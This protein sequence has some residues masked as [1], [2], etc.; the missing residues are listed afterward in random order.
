MD[1]RK[2]ALDKDR[3]EEGV[4]FETGIGDISVKVKRIGDSRYKEMLQKLSRPYRRQIERNTFD[5]DKAAELLSRALAEC[6]LVDWK[7]IEDAGKAVKF[8]KATAYQYL[9][10][11][12]ELREIVMEVAG[13]RE[14]FRVDWLE[15]S[16]K[17]SNRQ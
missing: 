10:E 4:W 16:A 9:V 8:S 6:I 7:N 13:E 11:F 15:E 5:D 2:L 1:I 3:V 17:N 14:A 12:D